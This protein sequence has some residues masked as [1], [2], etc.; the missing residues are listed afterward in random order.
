MGIGVGNVR[1]Q[2]VLIDVFV[3][4]P[5]TVISGPGIVVDNS[6]LSEPRIGRIDRNVLETAI[7]R[8]RRVGVAG[9]V[10]IDA[11]IVADQIVAMI[12]DVGQDH[13]V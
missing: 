8:R 9:Q 3:F 10:L 12:A 4:D 2:S 5:T 13:R 1:S 7:Q 11:V 6:H